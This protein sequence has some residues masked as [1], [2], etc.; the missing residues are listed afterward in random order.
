[1]NDSEKWQKAI[2][3]L[4]DWYHSDRLWKDPPPIN[5][6]EL[7]GMPYAVQVYAIKKFMWATHIYASKFNYLIDFLPD[8]YLPEIAEAAIIAAEK[9]ASPDR[10]SE[11]IAQIAAQQ[12]AALHPYLDR[13][14]EVMTRNDRQFGYDVQHAW[15]GASKIDN[16]KAILEGKQNSDETKKKAWE[17]LLETRDPAT[18][19][20][21]ITQVEVGHIV[22]A[23]D[24]D[25]WLIWLGYEWDGSNL[26]QLYSDTVYHLIFQ[27]EYRK[28][29]H[30]LDHPTH[31]LDTSGARKLAFGGVSSNTCWI[32][33]KPLHHVI[34][35]TP[36][37]V[38][39][40]IKN[41]EYVE[42]VTC[43]SCPD[44]ETGGLF[45]RHDEA[46]K[47]VSIAYGEPTRTLHMNSP[48]VM[49]AE[50]ALVLSPPRWQWQDWYSE[51]N[52]DRLGGNPFWLQFDEEYLNCPEC[53]KRMV[54]LMQLM[55]NLP[56]A[57]G[58]PQAWGD[59]GMGYFFWC[60][61]CAISGFISVTT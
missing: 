33:Q 50:V 19:R 29:Q 15:R 46:G 54:F 61:P 55:D 2:D 3:S 26:R 12:V 40:L 20:Y 38:G 51:G 22:T 5:D 14:F 58:R 6:S 28:H 56:E 11:A 30:H 34:T 35:I 21:A 13:L 36:E 1:M 4:F 47:A 10:V 32:C 57:N 43:L 42:L 27:R 8:E 9:G 24:L 17:C 45:Y 52:L 49:P 44:W 7:R 41:R 25:Q 18:M 16:L 39:L 48:G 53:G 37:L 60:D 59:T 31:N 23:A